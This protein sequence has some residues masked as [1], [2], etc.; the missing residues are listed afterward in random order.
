MLAYI[1]KRLAFDKVRAGGRHMM[2]CSTHAQMPSLGPHAPVRACKF[3]SLTRRPCTITLP[4]ELCA[5]G[6]T[7][8]HRRQGREVQE[9]G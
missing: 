8:R 4:T 9:G 5:C 2:R 3:R 6:C 1:K 7:G